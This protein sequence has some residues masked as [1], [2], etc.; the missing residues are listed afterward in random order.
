MGVG[1]NNLDDIDIK[2]FHISSENGL[3]FRVYKLADG[4]ISNHLSLKHF[5]TTSIQNIENMFTV[6]LKTIL[7]KQ[8]SNKLLRK[9]YKLSML[10]G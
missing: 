1:Y 10:W 4:T 9:L 6:D 8:A 7:D 2:E 5:D 3:V